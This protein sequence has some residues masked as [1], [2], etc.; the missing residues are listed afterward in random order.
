MTAQHQVAVV[1]GGAMG[2]GFAFSR[3]LAKQG[4]Q[5]IIADISD[6]ATAVAEQLSEHG[7]M[8]RAVHLDV[9]QE[10]SWQALV[11]DI[12]DHEGRLDVL[13]N[14]AGIAP[15][16]SVVETPLELWNQTIAVNLTGV[17]LGCKH[18]IPLMAE[19]EGGSIINIS[20]VY[21]QVADALTAAYSASKGGVRSLTKSSA[22]YCAGQAN[23]I[24][25]NSIHPGFVATPMVE[26]AL[27]NTPAEVRDPYIARTVGLTPLGR[28]GT[29]DDIVGAV[30]FLAGSGSRFMTGSEL[31]VD[32]GF[33]AR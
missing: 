28:I 2:L 10:S 24:R 5:V 22:L 8:V 33:T 21:G 31:T 18:A 26:N 27:A 14:N 30:L 19:A 15:P 9:S 13:V 4:L 23:G 16:G 17:F 6:R 25:V 1:T 11:D 32:G 20:S 3:A 12:R 29:P 7:L